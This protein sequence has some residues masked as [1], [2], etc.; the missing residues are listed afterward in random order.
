MGVSSPGTNASLWIAFALPVVVLL[1]LDLGLFLRSPREPTLKESVA[2]TAVWAGVAGIFGLTLTARLG[3]TEGLSFFTA[4][5]VEQALSVDNLFV[6]LLVFGELAVPG[7]ARKRAL[8]W[9]ILGAI[10]LRI[11][12]LGAGSAFLA[13]FHALGWALGALL[14]GMGLRS[15]VKLRREGQAGGES[16]EG[17]EGEEGGKATGAARASAFLG[18]WIPIHDHYDGDRFST[19]VGGRWTATPLLVAVAT[20][21]LADVVFALDS[22]PAVLGVSTTPIVIVTSN[23]LAV[24]GLRAMFFLLQGLLARLRYLPHGLAAVLVVVGGKMLLGVVVAIPTW[25]SLASVLSVLGVAIAFSL[26]AA[27]ASPTTVKG[28]SDVE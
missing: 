19:E 5:V 7:P 6:F 12:M 26:R 21:L 15:A 23:V 27:P 20:I 13:H 1:F 16:G 4:Y 10:V 9:G 18:R 2:W 8:A 25:L 11:A 14:V 17:G 22:I 3:A 24:L 28:T